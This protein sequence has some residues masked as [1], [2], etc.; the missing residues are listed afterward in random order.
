MEQVICYVA[1]VL[2][3]GKRGTWVRLK[4]IGR[5]Y[6]SWAAVYNALRRLNAWDLSIIREDTT[7]VTV[8]QGY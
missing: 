2:R 3:I 1:A 7:T 5:V 8:Y 4:Q 6:S